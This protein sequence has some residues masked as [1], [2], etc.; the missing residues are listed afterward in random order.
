MVRLRTA[1]LV[2]FFLFVAVTQV[3]AVTGGAN[4]TASQS[5]STTTGS[6]PG[7]INNDSV[8]PIVLAENFPGHS[9]DFRF[10]SRES[11]S[12]IFAVLSEPSSVSLLG[13]GLLVAG[14]IGRRQLRKR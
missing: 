4:L 8:T 14:Y 10:S 13:I 9:H 1:L 2:G 3:D 12:Q 5:S 11:H 6:G 7:A